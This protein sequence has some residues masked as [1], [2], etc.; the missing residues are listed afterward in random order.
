[1]VLLHHARHSLLVCFRFEPGGLSLL[2]SKRSDIDTICQAR[3]R[4]RTAMPGGPTWAHDRLNKILATL[5]ERAGK[6]ILRK[7]HD[8]AIL[9]RAFH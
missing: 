5:G 3:Q 7:C 9:R 6:S 2:G 8:G 1:M 4:C